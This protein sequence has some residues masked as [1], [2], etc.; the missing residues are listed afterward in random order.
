MGVG[1]IKWLQS[2]DILLIYCNN[3]LKKYITPLLRLAREHSLSP[4]WSQSEAFSVPFYTLIKLCY[5]K[6]FE[7]SSLVPGPKAKSSSEITNPTSFTIA[8]TRNKDILHIMEEPGGLQS[9]GSQRVGHD[10]V[11]SLH[12]TSHLKVC[13]CNTWDE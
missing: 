8:I 7:W 2:W 9:S 6:A 13:H 12:F 10:W 5:T 3:Q 1:L 4:F 11:T